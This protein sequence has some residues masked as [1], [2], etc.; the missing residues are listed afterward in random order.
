ML[1][2]EI[3]DYKKEFL[4]NVPA[5]ALIITVAHMFSGIEIVFLV[6]CAALFPAVLSASLIW[7]WLLGACVHASVEWEEMAW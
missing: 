1:R 7:A 2:I 5:M 6:V 3:R 4:K